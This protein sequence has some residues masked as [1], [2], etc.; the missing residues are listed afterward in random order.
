MKKYK[1]S[2]KFIDLELYFDSREEAE[3]KMK[4]WLANDEQEFGEADENDYYIVEE[5]CEM[6]YKVSHRPITIHHKSTKGT[7]LE[8][9]LSEAKALTE[10]EILRRLNAALDYNTTSEDGGCFDT[11]EGALAAARSFADLNRFSADQT[12]TEYRVVCEA[13]FIDE[14]DGEDIVGNTDVIASPDGSYI[15]RRVTY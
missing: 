1:L 2:G 15:V 10:D 8:A 4:E 9:V 3:A 14:D 12:Q 7:T 5:V 13:A 6:K 11:Y